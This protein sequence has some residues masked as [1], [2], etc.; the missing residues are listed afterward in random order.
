M[1]NEKYSI[2]EIRAALEGSPQGKEVEYIDIQ[3]LL[4]KLEKQN[5]FMDREEALI[6]FL[7]ELSKD[8]G[9]LTR[10]RR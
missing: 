2:S 6:R 8:G 5:R 1:K 4:K 7:Y 10:D 9:Q 3:S